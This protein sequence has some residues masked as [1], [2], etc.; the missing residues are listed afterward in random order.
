MKVLSEFTISNLNIRREKAGEEDGDLGCDISLK[1]SLSAE[2]CG[3]FFSTDASRRRVLD[4]LWNEEGE[5]TTTDVAK[6]TLNTEIKGGTVILKT[7]FSPAETFESADINKVTLVPKSGWT[8]EV[9]MRAQVNPTAEQMGRLSQ[10]LGCDV[11]VAADRKQGELELQAPTA[12]D[13]ASEAAGDGSM[14]PGQPAPQRAK[15]SKPAATL[16]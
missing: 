5:L 7:E 10:L 3:S 15:R 13:E 9:S 14:V 2:A 12:E 8:C 16:Q 6:I 11:H 4:D 1:S